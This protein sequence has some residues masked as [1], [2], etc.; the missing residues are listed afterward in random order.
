MEK[1]LE[2][3]MS[4]PY[5]IEITPIKSSLG[6]GFSAAIPQLGRFALVGD[7]ETIE[8]A[9]ANLENAKRERF[10]EYLEN[11]LSIPEPAEEKE[12]FSGRFVVR[13]PKSLHAQLVENAKENGV[14]LNHL[15]SYLL[16][17]NLSLGLY[18]KCVDDIN[19]NLKSIG[20]NTWRMRIHTWSYKSEDPYS[21]TEGTQMKKGTKRAFRIIKRAA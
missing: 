9:L 10:K 14:S 12:S 16:S 17:T 21:E 7:G 19:R 6:G 18:K 2:H 13:V 20:E 5:V 11:G 15:V 4:L 1:S 8:K 3:Y